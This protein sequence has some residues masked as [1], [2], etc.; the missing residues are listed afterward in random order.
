MNWKSLFVLVEKHDRCRF[1]NWHSTFVSG[2]LGDLRSGMRCAREDT[3]D[4]YPGDVPPTEN[5]RS[6]RIS[7]AEQ[8]LS[9]RQEWSQVLWSDETWINDD[10]IMSGHVTRKVS[11]DQS[12]VQGMQ[13]SNYIKR[14]ARNLMILV[15]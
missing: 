13:I 1:S 15:S 5:H 14:E 2:A 7:W 9:W 11:I 4:V 10:R 3:K 8:H 12:I 6:V